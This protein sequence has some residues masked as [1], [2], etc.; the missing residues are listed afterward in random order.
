LLLQRRHLLQE[1]M[2]RPNA[3]KI[4]NEIAEEKVDKLDWRSFLSV[5]LCMREKL[6]ARRWDWEI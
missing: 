5:G 6:M 2:M 4:S 3:E 1:D